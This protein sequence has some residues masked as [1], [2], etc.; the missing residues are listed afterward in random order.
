MGSDIV[1]RVAV[2]ITNPTSLPLRW[3][4]AIVLTAPVSLPLLLL[5]NAAFYAALGVF[6]FVVG[7]P[8]LI[9]EEFVKPMWAEHSQETNH[10]R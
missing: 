4:R 7:I 3:R 8:W 5:A 6:V 1:K 10:D 2:G 9:F